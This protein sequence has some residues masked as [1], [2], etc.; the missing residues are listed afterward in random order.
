MAPARPSG[1]SGLVIHPRPGGRTPPPGRAGRRVPARGPH[2][3]RRVGQDLT[4]P[5][6]WSNR[7]AAQCGRDRPSKAGPSAS[8]ASPRP[9]GHGHERLVGTQGDQRRPQRLGRRAA[10]PLPATGGTVRA[11]PLGRDPAASPAFVG[12]GRHG[13]SSSHGRAPDGRRPAATEDGRRMDRPSRSARAGPRERPA[14]NPVEPRRSPEPPPATGPRMAAPR[15][16]APPGPPATVVGL[17]RPER[18]Q[19]PATGLEPCPAAARPPAGRPRSDLGRLRRR[20]PAD[21]PRQADD[22]ESVRPQA[23]LRPRPQM[24]QLI[25]GATAGSSSHDHL[26]R[27]TARPRPR[28]TRPAAWPP[29]R[30]FP[31]PRPRA[32]RPGPPPRVDESPAAE[33]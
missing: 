30:T 25:R 20:A 27:P 6:R 31:P 4:N 18:M 22:V 2:G 16:S 5:E 23:S 11:P 19:G 32:W 28:R 8:P 10:G 3:R 33:P 12:Q 24:T 26:R 29:P 17:P 13:R 1:T 14:T 7:P 9:G 21:R 15:P